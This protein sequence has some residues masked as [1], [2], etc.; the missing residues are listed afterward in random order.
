MTPRE[1]KISC[2]KMKNPVA[3]VMKG[4]IEQDWPT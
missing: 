4:E 3:S 2:F 1:G